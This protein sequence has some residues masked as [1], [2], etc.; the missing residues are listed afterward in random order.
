MTE[1]SQE[2]TGLGNYFV[3]NYPPFSAWKPEHSIL[4]SR[5]MAWELNLA[6]W[7]DLAYGEI[8]GR[9]SEHKYT[10]RRSQATK[11]AAA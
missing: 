5:L 7:T 6:W 1:S 9:D 3:A 4:V 11:P 2:K 8:A 10:L